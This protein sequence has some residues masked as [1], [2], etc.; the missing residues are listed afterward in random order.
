M[1]IVI[2]KATFVWAKKSS[3]HARNTLI[4][5]RSNLSDT[6]LLHR[7][8]QASSRELEK[9]PLSQ[10]YLAQH[11]VFIS[12]TTSPARIEKIVPIL[13]ALDLSLVEEVW[14]NI[15]QVFARTGER[16]QIPDAL[17]HTPKVRIHEVDQDYGPATKFLPGVIRARRLDSKAIVIS[18]DDDHAY[19]KSVVAEHIYAIAHGAKVSNIIDAR[20]GDLANGF[21]ALPKGD[22][23]LYAAWPSQDY[24]LI[25]G[26]SSVAYV[27]EVVPVGKIITWLQQEQA[28]AQE[29]EASCLFSDDF[30]ITYALAFDQVPI[31][32]LQTEYAQCTDILP[33][34]Y[35]LSDDALHRQRLADGKDWQLNRMNDFTKYRLEKCFAFL[36]EKNSGH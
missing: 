16:Y 36:L 8:A 32:T 5:Q 27:A 10:A 29:G 34:S 2:L 35:G 26:W 1:L 21:F 11:P 7:A 22:P 6:E 33:L 28:E 9:D 4:Y 24:T 20:A 3:I 31:T 14:I 17:V 15:P 19:P 13:E 23:N 12:M 25:H 30:L 18:L